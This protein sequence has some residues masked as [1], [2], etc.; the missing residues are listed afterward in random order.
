MSTLPKYLTKRKQGFYAVMEIPKPLRPAL[1]MKPRFLQSLGT[2]DQKL[3]ERRLP[4]IVN[5]WKA[6]LEKLKGTE[7]DSSGLLWEILQWKKTIEETQDETSKDVATD[8]AYDWVVGLEAKHGLEA[9]KEAHGIIFSDIQPLGSHIETWAATIG[10][11]DA[12]TQSLQKLAVSDLCAYFKTNGNI[13]KTTVKE[14]LTYLRTEKNLSDKTITIRLSSMRSFM[15]HMDEAFGT[16]LLPLFTSKALPRM[17]TAKTTKQRAWIPFTAAEVSKLYDAALSKK[18]P[19]HALADLIAFG[20]YT[21][22]RIEELAQL[23]A[24]HFSGNAFKVEDSKTAAGIREVPVHPALANAVQRLTERAKDG[25][26]LE[27]SDEGAFGKRSDA[28]GKRFGKLKTGLGFGPQHV[29]HSIRKT[30]VSQLEQAGVNENTTADIVG[31]D[32][33]RITYGLYSAGASTAQKAEALAKVAYEGKLA[34]PD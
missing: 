10:H 29:F 34:I 17:T 19:D 12:K 1:N 22:C 3:A 32:K 21:G 9:S 20:A 7:S 23:K 8:M 28:L 16:D 26:L 2:R 33:P 18:K 6:Q 24:E 15:R 27:G 14:Y 11:L 5:R 30:V 31:H 13:N 25:Y 4:I